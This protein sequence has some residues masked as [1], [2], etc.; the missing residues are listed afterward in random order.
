[1]HIFKQIGVQADITRN[2]ISLTT[3]VKLIFYHLFGD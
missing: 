2:S 3:V 1:M